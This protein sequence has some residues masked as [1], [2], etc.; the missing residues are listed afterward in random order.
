ME[1]VDLTKLKGQDLFLYMTE[2]LEDKDY[3]S[4]VSLLQYAEPDQEKAFALLEKVAQEGKRL[5]AV[6]PGLNEKPEPGMQLI[7]DIPDGALYII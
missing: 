3:S 4:T 6:Y 5:V 7:G 1:K 2:Y